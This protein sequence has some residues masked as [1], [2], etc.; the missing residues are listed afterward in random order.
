MFGPSR[1]AGATVAFLVAACVTVAPASASPGVPAGTAVTNKFKAT[2]TS[3]FG[4]TVVPDA[5]TTTHMILAANTQCEQS[6]SA[7][8]KVGGYAPD[9]IRKPLARRRAIADWRIKVE[10]RHGKQFTTWR[11]AKDRNVQCEASLGSLHCVAEASPCQS[12]ALGTFF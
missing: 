12:A 8:G 10:A 1:I 4:T 11:Q 2:V 5:I 7:H 9:I 6:I 3:T